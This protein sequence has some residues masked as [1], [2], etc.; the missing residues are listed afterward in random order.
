[1][2]FT[3]IL[4]IYEENFNDFKRLLLSIKKNKFKKYEVIIIDDSKYLGNKTNNFKELASNNSFRYI[5]NKKKLGLSMSCNL[6][7]SLA[8]GEYCIFLNCDNFISSDF[9]SYAY[10]K[11]KSKKLDI[12]MQ[13]NKVLNNDNKYGHYIESQ[14]VRNQI[15]GARIKKLIQF[16]FISYTEGFIAKKK[17]LIQSGGFFDHPENFFR[18]GEDF[19]FASEIRKI[20]NLKVSIDFHLTV[21]HVI[22]D[23][24]KSFFHNRFIRGYGTPQINYYYQNKSLI[25]CNLFFIFKNAIKISYILLFPLYFYHSF[26]FYKKFVNRDILS[27]KNFL[28]LKL[29][30]DFSVIYGEITSLLKI[31]LFFRNK[32]LIN[33]HDIKT[34]K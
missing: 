14:S 8:K 1:M 27:L 10:K 11:I 25:R 33:L 7:I 34:S 31:N 20:L 2:I 21:K 28:Y 26:N 9:F 18:A 23:D 16:N 15:N 32:K 6:A 3:V 29:F 24:K 22:P 19:I 4:P 12:I 17:V 13:Y 5:N 30:E